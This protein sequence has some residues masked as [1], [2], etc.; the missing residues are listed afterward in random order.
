MKEDGTQFT[1]NLGKAALRLWPDLPRDVQ[2]RPFEEVVAGHESLRQSLALY[3][4]N[5]H[6]RTAHP[7][8]PTALAWGMPELARRR[9]GPN[10]PAA[11]RAFQCTLWLD[12]TT[13]PVFQT[14]FSQSIRGSSTERQTDRPQSVGHRAGVQWAPLMCSADYRRQSACDP[15]LYSI[16]QSRW[17]KRRRQAYRHFPGSASPARCSAGLLGR[18]KL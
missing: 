10:G 18:L 11:F 17:F 12:S 14:T 13:V 2:E 5:R 6:P 15:L 3:L 9:H 7:S 8:G 1:D 16:G 4:H